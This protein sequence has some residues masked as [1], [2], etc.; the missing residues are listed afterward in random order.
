M[1]KGKRPARFRGVHRHLDHKPNI[2]VLGH[3]IPRRLFDAYDSR[4]LGDNNGLDIARGAKTPGQVY[5][6]YMNFSEKFNEVNFYPCSKILSHEYLHQISQI[7]NDNPDLVICQLGTN[8]LA[9]EY[10]CEQLIVNALFS[11]AKLFVERFKIDHVIF[12]AE[13][14]RADI[15]DANGLGNLKCSVE[16]FESR[17]RK[18]N[19]LVREQC[20][21]VLEFEQARLPGFW[22]DA[23]HN[24]IPIEVWTTDRLHPGPDPGHPGFLKYERGIR[25]VLSDGVAQVCHI[26]KRKGLL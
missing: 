4:M 13:F 8:D 21:Q 14:K 24:E 7:G 22:F 16:D 2:A 1:P 25:A 20:E 23:N 17:V 3:S 15:P 10:A 26:K 12:L 18:F 11:S 19:E 5:A 6:E 9:S